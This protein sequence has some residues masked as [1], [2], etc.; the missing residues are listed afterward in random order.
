M[1]GLQS[2]TRRQSYKENKSVVP[3]TVAPLQYL[4]A[5]PLQYL[6]A[7]DLVNQIHH[8]SLPEDP[9]IEA[10]RLACSHNPGPSPE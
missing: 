7:K 3:L 1:F 2:S 5:A 4:A 8:K 10:S 9:S 6:A